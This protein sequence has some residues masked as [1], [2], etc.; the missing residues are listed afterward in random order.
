MTKIYYSNKKQPFYLIFLL[1][2]LT[3]A[4]GG[5]L[6]LVPDP[7]AGKPNI[8]GY[9]SLCTFAPAATFFCFSIAGL[10]CTIR[11]FL[12]KTDSDGKHSPISAHLFALIPIGLLLLGGI[13]STGIWAG[14]AAIYSSQIVTQIQ[15]TLPAG[16]TDGT[17]SGTW[18][19]E[20]V[21]A[22]VELVIRD[23]KILSGRLTSS[24]NVP[25]RIAEAIFNGIIGTQSLQVDAVTGA[26]ASCSVL[27]K[28]CERALAISAGK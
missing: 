9:L 21:A 2:T 4:L 11:A 15:T 25:A 5:I 14:S 26:T 6:T 10:S 28:A 3:G 1:I 18:V 17:F 20:E 19:T 8:L 24:R 27:L 22:T 23:G 7:M 13:V 12:F 16:I